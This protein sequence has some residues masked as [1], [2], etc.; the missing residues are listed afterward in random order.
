VHLYDPTTLAAVLGHSGASDAPAT[1][2]PRTLAQVQVQEV[3]GDT[4]VEI[5]P[6]QP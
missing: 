3:S 5:L 6:A 2:A 4:M 1:D